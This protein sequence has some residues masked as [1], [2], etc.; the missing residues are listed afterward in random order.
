MKHSGILSMA[1]AGLFLAGCGASGPDQDPPVVAFFEGGSPSAFFASDGSVRAGGC[2]DGL[3]GSHAAFAG[4][5]ANIHARSGGEVAKL[6]VTFS[7]PSGIK[8]AYLQIPGGA[9]VSP[10]TTS[11][12]QVPTASGD[13]AE[14]YEYNFYGDEA[15]PQNTHTVIVEVTH[16]DANRVFNA[17]AVDMN[18]NRS[19]TS[20]LL[21]GERSRICG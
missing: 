5:P 12:I 10:Q 4:G 1:A 16:A 20:S 18:D 6:R 8:R 17:F 2:A 13:V 11:R 19:A 3:A 9:L 14:A 21:I 15:A 7:D